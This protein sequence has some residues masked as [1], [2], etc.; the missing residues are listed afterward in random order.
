MK[1]TSIFTGLLIVGGISLFL[2]WCIDPYNIGKVPGNPH[3]YVCDSI[4][5]APSIQD[6]T[7]F[8]KCD[9]VR[10]GDSLTFFGIIVPYD[11]RVRSFKWDYADGMQ[12]TQAISIH[13]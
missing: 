9:T 2:V 8:S 7:R 4:I 10:P 11:P 5:K 12:D 1:R 6:T 3:A 13:S